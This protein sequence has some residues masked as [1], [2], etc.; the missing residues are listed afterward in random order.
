MP[1]RRD[2]K[3]DWGFYGREKELDWLHRSLGL[4]VG[5]KDRGFNC[6]RVTGRRGI[7]KSTLMDRAMRG[8]T[9]DTPHVYIEIGRN[10]TTKDVL[11]S[12]VRQIRR[13]GHAPL[14]AGR[15]HLLTDPDD[16]GFRHVPD[17]TFPDQIFASIVT[18]LLVKGAVVTIDE[19]QR[20]R[21]LLACD[22]LRTVV[23]RFSKNQNMA[24]GTLVLTG[25]HQQLMREMFEQSQEWYGR[26]DAALDIGLW[27]PRT[28]LGMAEERGLLER[29]DRFL[30]LWATYGGI[31]RLWERFL[32]KDR[33]GR[34]ERYFSLPDANSWRRDFIDGE[35]NILSVN[36][37]ERFDAAAYVLFEKWGREVML[38]LGREP[39]G[40]LHAEKL[41]GI[42]NARLPE[43]DRDGLTVDALEEEL[44]KIRSHMGYVRPHDEFLGPS[45]APGR[46]TI[47]DRY[48]EFQIR[49][50]PEFHGKRHRSEN[51]D[52]AR[53]SEILARQRVRALVDIE[54]RAFEKFA[55]D[56]LRNLPG[57]EWASPG[58]W[59]NGIRE[60]VDVT[61]M[62]GYPDDRKLL[63]GT[64]KM[65]AGNLDPKRDIDIFDRFLRSIRS[66]SGARRRRRY[67]PVP[68]DLK[69][70]DARVAANE[71][72][73]NPDNIRRMAFSV[74]FDGRKRDFLTETG[75][76]TTD[77]LDMAAAHGYGPRA[78]KEPERFRAPDLPERPAI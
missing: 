37:D 33:T 43:E 77:I 15:E 26:C 68:R 23:D 57:V 35:A 54:G 18:L 39:S 41:V 14:F 8:T 20:M 73:D 7:G 16:E 34:L 24:C 25:S 62:T 11:K 48:A 52:L 45:D 70:H 13:G 58:C 71:W 76:E 4:R 2:G 53:T 6:L 74:A 38:A 55:A 72:Q 56:W 44:G 61:A 27:T 36:S 59:R 50:F 64:C 63:L 40:V 51:V 78:A 69:G 17:A 22:A 31:P 5:M 75:F 19:F 47:D 65:R 49:V 32:V 21:D 29:P 28:I 9:D 42:L 1:S 10:W 12:F 46:W 67:W 66:T 60:D 30:T 3:P